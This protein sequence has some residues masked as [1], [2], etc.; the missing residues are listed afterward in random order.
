MAV[1]GLRKFYWGFLFIM[2]DFRIMGIDI[3]PDIIG[4]ILFAMGFSALLEESDHFRSARDL[5]IPMIILSIFTIYERPAGQDGGVHFHPLWPLGILV[6]VAGIILTLMVVYRLFMGI[7]EMAGRREL[8]ELSVEAG[9]RWSQFLMLQLAVVGAFILFIIPPLAV[10]YVIA[11]L[12]ASII[13]T[14]VIMGFIKRC[15]D[16]F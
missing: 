16:N 14:V 4:F 8:R 9:Q 10:I 1:E 13:L 2:V 5:N 11:L 6:G 3:L 12:I 15:E 7:E